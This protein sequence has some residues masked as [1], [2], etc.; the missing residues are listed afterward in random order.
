M[1]VADAM[2]GVSFDRVADSYDA[3]RRL[4]DPVMAD[5]LDALVELLGT[6]GRV[7]EAGV[8]TGRFAVP[9][10]SRGV[11]VVGVDI[12]PRM[13]ATAWGKGAPDLF[14]AS[15]TCLPFRDGSF[16]SSLAIHVLHLVTDWRGIL[17]EAARVTRG[18]FLTLFETITTRRIG[19]EASFAH[20]DAVA[21]PMPRYQELAADRGH[22]YRH[23]GVRP[24]DLIARVPPSLRRPVGA[25]TLSFTG[26]ELLEP[27]AAKTH[28]SQWDV[29]DAVHR[30]IMDALRREV[31]G[32]RFARTWDVEVVGWTPDAL[33]RF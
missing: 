30:E 28:S 11:R 6:E 17:H 20:G 1:P 23:P 14:L 33:W 22:G 8:G 15:A 16:R 26:A 9:L 7:L 31:E 12:A 25:H 3:T 19:G 29:P 10:R 4:P 32:S 24:P 27:I 18:M 2:A 21:Y 5:A 13:I